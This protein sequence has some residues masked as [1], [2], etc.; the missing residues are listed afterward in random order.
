MN[1]RGRGR[2]GVAEAEA[3]VKLEE[4]LAFELAALIS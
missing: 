4:A 2:A 1:R 3:V